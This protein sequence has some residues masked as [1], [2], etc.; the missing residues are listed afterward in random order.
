MKT[1]KTWQRTKRPDRGRDG[2][3][4]VISLLLIGLLSFL[5][6]TVYQ[7]TRGEVFSAVYQQRH[8]TAFFQTE[9]G[10]RYALS[11]LSQMVY[12]GTL[13]MTNLVETVYIPPPEGYTFEPITELHRLPNGRWYSM[14]VTGRHENAKSVI[15]ATVTRPR[16]LA[17]TG[18]FGNMDLRL[19]PN[20]EIYSYD[21]RDLLNPTPANSTGQAN[22]G[23]NILITM[24]NNIILDGLVLVGM[25]EFGAQGTAP[26]GYEYDL[27]ERIE[28]DPLG[29]R[30]GPLAQFFAFYSDPAHN[31]NATAGILNNKVD[32]KPN[33]PL[34]MGGGIYYI[35]DMYVGPNCTINV[36]A[37]PD[38]PAIVF[39]RG[40]MR[41]QPGCIFNMNNGEPTNL[42]IFSDSEEEVRLQPSNIFR[43]LV[44]A[45][46]ADLQIQPLG[47]MCG[48]FWGNT[49]TLQ[50]NEEIYIDLALLDKFRSV[51]VRMVQWEEI[52]D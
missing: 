30:D 1:N 33:V 52:V 38:N 27:V 47:V 49:A 22:I 21:S 18:I 41:L 20:E 9:A 36:T 10:V 5:A 37:T 15:R 24:L 34:E 46:Y 4:L 48:V 28:P 14:T 11:R 7:L 25:D 50:P 45:P 31:D 16:M 29:A 17:G 23:S 44:Y 43:G 35:E 42:M 40:P 8:S 51:N 13:E 26:V 19:Q 2:A 32:V 12:D 39:L 3:A 6:A